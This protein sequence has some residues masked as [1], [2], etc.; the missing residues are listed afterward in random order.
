M[1]LNSLKKILLFSCAGNKRLIETMVDDE[2]TCTNVK[3]SAILESRLVD[4]FLTI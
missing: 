3:S 1:E 2:S 4:S